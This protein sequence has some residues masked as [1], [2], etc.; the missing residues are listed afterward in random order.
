MVSEWTYGIASSQIDLRFEIWWIVMEW[1]LVLKC[2]KDDDKELDF[3]GNRN[4]DNS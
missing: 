1:G 3:L 4:Y 2:W